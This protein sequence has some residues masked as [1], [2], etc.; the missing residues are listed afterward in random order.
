MPVDG[1]GGAEFAVADAHGVYAVWTLDHPHRKLLAFET[2]SNSASSQL[3][4]TQLIPPA[5][6]PTPGRVFRGPVR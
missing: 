1:L 4:S 2:R 3:T 6:A 5:S